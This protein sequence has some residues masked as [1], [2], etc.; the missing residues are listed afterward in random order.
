MER[1][2]AICNLLAYGCFIVCAG[3]FIFT[4]AVE[5]MGVILITLIGGIVLKCIPAYWGDAPNIPK[6][7]NPWAQGYDEDG[8]YSWYRQSQAQANN[9]DLADKIN[10]DK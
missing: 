6:V 8:N 5:S 1:R 7:D 4:D 3:T 2:T 9:Q 10:K